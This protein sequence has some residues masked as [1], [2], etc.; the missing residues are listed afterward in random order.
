MH[1]VA[2]YNGNQIVK[3]ADFI[4]KQKG[5]TFQEIT[6]F[7]KWSCFDCDTDGSMEKDIII[8]PNCSSYSLWQET[9]EDRDRRVN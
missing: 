6:K 4:L 2:T 7:R 9:K 5:I 1:W 3:I 8:C